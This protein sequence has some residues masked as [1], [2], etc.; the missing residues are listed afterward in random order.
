MRAIIAFQNEDGER[1]ALVRSIEY[2]NI[3]ITDDQEENIR[4][5]IIS[6]QSTATYKLKSDM[7]VSE[8]AM[9]LTGD[10]FIV[11]N[12]HNEL[13]AIQQFNDLEPNF[14]AKKYEREPRGL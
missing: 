3:V 14:L 10:L 2:T 1:I 5:F 12:S 13:I 6:G 4:T 8:F 9:F 11:S 7:E